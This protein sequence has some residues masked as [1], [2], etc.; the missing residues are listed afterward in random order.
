MFDFNSYLATL[1]PEQQKA[2]K[3]HGSPLLILA[4][5][6][7]GKT[8]IITAKIAFLVR[9]RQ[10]LPESILAVTFTNKAAKEMRDRAAR[11]EPA[12]SR[13]IIRTF[14]SFGA[15][16]LRRN[17]SLVG[18]SP[19]FVI[20][21]D[22]DSA[23]L[24]HSILPQMSKQECNHLA[25]LI[26]RA[27]DYYLDPD[28]PNL[29]N[30]FKEKDFRR[31]FA[32]YQERLRKT[33]NVDF[34]DLIQLPAKILEQD[35][36]IAR[37]TRQRFRVILVDEYQDSNVAQFILLQRLTGPET[38]LCVVGDDDQSIYRFRGAEVKNILSFSKVFPNTE[39]IRIEQNYRSSQTILDIAGNSVSHNRGR[40]GKSLRATKPGGRKPQIALLDDQEQEVEFCARIIKQH[41]Q[42]GG[43]YSD[44]AILYRTNAQSLSFE[45]E[46]PRR[47][48]PYKLVGALRFYE[49]EEVKDVLAYLSLIQNP[50][51]EI[52]FKRIV[53]KPARGIGDSSIDKISSHALR[54]GL[55]LTEACRSMKDE[56]RGKGKEGLIRFLDIITNSV[57]MLGIGQEPETAREPY[58][59]YDGGRQAK[60]KDSQS[61]GQLLEYIIK[62]SGLIEYHKSQDE[63]AGTQ[64]LSNLDEL[65]NAASLYPL[66]Q[67]GLREF[68]ETI[69][70][71]RSFQA[72]DQE[73]A[74]DA[75]TLITMHNTKGLE[76]PVVIVTGMEQGLFPRDDEEG[77]DLEEQRRL[78]YVAMTRAKDLL[79]L[80]ACRWRRM[81]G[82]LFE[83]SPSRFLMELDRSLYDI[84]GRRPQT[85]VQPIAAQS[86]RL[87]G[88]QGQFS[89]TSRMAAAGSRPAASA[90]SG[91]GSGRIDTAGG[92][93]VPAE[94]AASSEWMTGGHVYHDEYGQ[95]VIIKVSMTESSGPLVIVQ[96]ET[97]K[98][99]QFFPKYTKKLERISG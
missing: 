88:A 61:L 73:A 84:W 51:D 17:A 10:I 14:H 91:T 3:H 83:T 4:G 30:L 8:T 27:K 71:D 20:Y 11:L 77:E 18:L 95:G 29:D 96:F 86:P 85:A 38:Y 81:R 69:E 80:T 28:S 68:L 44:I 26:A 75:V 25:S 19:D 35:E 6:G 63:I 59:I 64:K 94:K 24:L 98:V 48:I 60:S 52:A 36:A 47:D 49:R 7:T 72:A 22:S 70:L 9:E 21:D 55:S 42:A 40:L 89:T 12:C 31:I 97:G 76:F 5:A 66:V 65:I 34:G 43:R 93:V 37:R 45:K 92:T 39:I 79:Y 15:W 16:F 54:F 33:G 56:M 32:M 46:F 78:F 58:S 87:G 2:V 62:A 74:A 41:Y 53:N 57:A 23:E 67:D 90:P 99:A 1:N 50:H 13:A 82:R